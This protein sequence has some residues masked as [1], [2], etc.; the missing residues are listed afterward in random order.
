[1]KN[2]NPNVSDDE[3]LALAAWAQAEKAKRLGTPNHEIVAR[4]DGSVS[5]VPCGQGTDAKFTQRSLRD[6]GGTG[7]GAGALSM[8]FYRTGGTC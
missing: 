5:R 6:Q 8:Q 7:K 2:L 3:L 4:F 1:M